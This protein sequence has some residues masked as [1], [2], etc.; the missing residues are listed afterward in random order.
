M[1]TL[2]LKDLDRNNASS[3]NSLF[4][5]VQMLAMRFSV[6]AAAAILGTFMNR[7]H[8]HGDAL[9]SIKAFHTTF[10]CM[11]T[12]TCISV[13]IFWQLSAFTKSKAPITGHWNTSRRTL[14]SH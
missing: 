7:F 12:L 3:G 13:W 8:A 5:M 4:S 10:I 2:T 9:L 14:V 6:A 1:N 11:G